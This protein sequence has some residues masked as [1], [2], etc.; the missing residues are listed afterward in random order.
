MGTGGNPLDLQQAGTF[1]PAWKGGRLEGG[2]ISK[3]SWIRPT[4]CRHVDMVPRI[5]MDWSFAEGALAWEQV[6]PP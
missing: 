4:L 6:A 3:T 5:Q 2:G 1:K